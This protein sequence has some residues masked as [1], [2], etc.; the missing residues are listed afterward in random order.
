[1]KIN[2]FDQ[3]KTAKY[4]YIIAEIGANHNGDMD[5]AKKLIDV[6]KECGADSVKFQSW[7]PSSLISQEEY[8]RNTK[9]NDS[10]KKHFGSLREMVEAYYLREEQHFELKAYCDKLNIDFSSSTF[11]N[12][13]TN[14]L[15]KLDIP[16]IKIA[17]MDINNI[18]LIEYAAR[19]GKP[20][21]LSTGM[22]DLSEIEIAIKT[23]EK[24]N[25]FQIFLLH[26]ISIYPPKIKDINLNNI[27]ML[28]QTFGYPVG[29]SDHSFGL[30]IPLAAITLGAC[31]I[32]KH[33]TLDKN[34]PGWDHEISADPSELK[35]IVQY[36]KEV[37]D[38]LGEFKRIVSADELSKRIKFR[39]SIVVSGDLNK[40]HVITEG[41]LLFKRPGTGIPPNEA[42]YL[43][44]RKLKCN[45][46]SDTLLKWEDF[47]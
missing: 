5:I 27:S 21:M 17:S 13:E 30:H 4:P 44:G 26:C 1:M 31:I 41:D 32:E 3:L 40:G 35:Q 24:Q 38:S 33:F 20:I 8:D 18:S 43:I 2:F 23:I 11:S 37:V 34:M 45:L 19:T 39:R 36:G 6:A 14:M 15:M 28:K 9:Y 12:E 7:T 25:N 16:F 22:A 47:E 46:S 42:E 29:F 10:P